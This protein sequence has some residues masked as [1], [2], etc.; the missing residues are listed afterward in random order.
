[1]QVSHLMLCHKRNVRI[2]W[3]YNKYMCCHFFLSTV[4]VDIGKV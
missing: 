4:V 2:R 1:M 3:G